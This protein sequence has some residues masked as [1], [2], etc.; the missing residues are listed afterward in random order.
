MAPSKEKEHDSPRKWSI[1][2]RCIIVV[3]LVLL[4][5][6]CSIFKPPRTRKYIQYPVEP[7]DTLREISQRF[8]VELDELIDLNDIGDPKSL[9][10]GRVLNVPFTG[11]SVRKSSQTQISSSSSTA[12]TADSK[13][14]D[15]N[16]KKSLALGRSEREVG[17][18]FWPTGRKGYLSSR[19]GRRWFSFHEGI[20]IAA[21]SGTPIY[22]AHSGTVVYSGA[23]LRG[24]GN[25]IVVKGD[26]LL[27]VYA[28]NRRNRVDKGEKVRRGEH[29]ADIGQSGKATGPHLHFEVRVRDSSGKNVAVDP[30]S[31]FPGK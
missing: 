19:F 16:S 28:H 5:S 2:T 26:N 18:L 27:T 14:W 23:G 1:D 24:Y 20:D 8:Q 30:L 4:L 15:P 7:G 9:Q 10:I 31:F 3:V 22:A 12:R 17:R 29:I 25:L 6:A 11:Q 13:R 21:V